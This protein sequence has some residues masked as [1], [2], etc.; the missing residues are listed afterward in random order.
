MSRSRLGQKV[1]DQVQI[2]VKTSSSLFSFSYLFFC[3]FA[4]V[5]IFSTSLFLYL[6]LYIINI[7]YSSFLTYY[8]NFFWV[9]CMHKLLSLLVD[10]CLIIISKLPN[11]GL[12]I[13]LSLFIYTDLLFF[14]HFIRQKL[15]IIEEVKKSKNFSIKET[16]Q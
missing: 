7:Y 12:S 2:V 11:S 13:S 9:Y 3:F 8:T 14:I 16:L 10:I 4:Y 6:N 1:L 5:S 15:N